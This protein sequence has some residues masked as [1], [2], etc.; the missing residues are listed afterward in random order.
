MG[1]YMF[2][3]LQAP[4]CTL[5]DDNVHINRTGGTASFVSDIHRAVGLYS[6]SRPNRSDHQVYRRQGSNDAERNHGRRG[7]AVTGD[8]RAGARHGA[9]PTVKYKREGR[10]QGQQFNLDQMLKLVTLN[11]L[12]SMQMGN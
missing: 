5:Y 2:N 1:S 6:R 7:P 3:I 4:D 11:M 8:S 10:D 12:Q 9:G